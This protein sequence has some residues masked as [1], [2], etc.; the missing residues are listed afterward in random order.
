[1]TPCS[2][3]VPMIEPSPDVCSFG[4]VLDIGDKPIE[5]NIKLLLRGVFARFNAI[6]NRVDEFR[7]Y[8][9]HGPQPVQIPR[10]VRKLHLVAQLRAGA[11]LGR[12]ATGVGG[13]AFSMD[14][15]EGSGADRGKVRHTDTLHV[16]KLR[17]AIAFNPL[18]SSAGSNPSGPPS[19]GA[20]LPLTTISTTCEI[21]LQLSDKSRFSVHQSG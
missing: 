5:G 9:G 6:A 21:P 3:I 16:F 14:R 11:R 12:S 2:R 8:V 17:D 20:P 19:L 4:H 15:P 7:P 1:M 10:P 18:L 13:L